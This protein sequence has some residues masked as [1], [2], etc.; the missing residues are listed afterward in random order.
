MCIRDSVGSTHAMTTRDATLDHE[1]IREI[2]ANVTI[3][4]VLHGSSGVAD[5]QLRSAVQAG[6]RKVNVGTALNLAYSRAIRVAMDD[7]TVSDPRKYLSAARSAVA[8]TV[9][10]LCAVVA[11]PMSAGEGQQR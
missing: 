8:D 2:A 10:Q 6:I 7:A 3:P 11:A 9:A 5:D 1:L 4:L